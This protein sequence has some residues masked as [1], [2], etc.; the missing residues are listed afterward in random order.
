M[1]DPSNPRTHRPPPSYH[2]EAN[3][4]KTARP[5]TREADMTTILFGEV[6]DTGNDIG[7]SGL[8]EVKYE[9]NDDGV[10]RTCA[11]PV[12]FYWMLLRP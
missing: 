10:W 11:A 2:D 3:A 12:K 8:L 9:I 7:V 4:P 1:T 5:T 6:T